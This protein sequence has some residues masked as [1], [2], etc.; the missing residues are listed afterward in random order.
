MVKKVQNSKCKIKNYRAN[1][2]EPS[3]HKGY[4]NY[5]VIPRFNRGNQK[6]R[7]WIFW[8]SQRMTFSGQTKTERAY[9]I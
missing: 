4:E 3:A 8:S 7:I 9:G 6:K 2:H 5:L 1:P